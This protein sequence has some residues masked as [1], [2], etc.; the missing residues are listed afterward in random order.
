[1]I[2]FIGDSTFYKHFQYY[3]KINELKS[4]IKIY[5]N[6]VKENK[7]KLNSL[8]MDNESLER[9]AREQFLMTKNDEELYIIT[10]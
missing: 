3:K 10:P 5:Q 8:H 4:D 2:G 6:K 7:D 9:F 1:M